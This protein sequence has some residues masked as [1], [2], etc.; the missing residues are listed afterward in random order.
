MAEV[1][2]AGMR[3]GWEQAIDDPAWIDYNGHL[4]VAFYALIFDQAVDAALDAA[5]LG[6]AYRAATGCSVFVLETH[7]RFAAEVAAGATVQVGSRLLAADRRRAVFHHRMM[8]AGTAAAVALQEAL[9]IHVDLGSR[10]SLPW[11]PAVAA[12]L[13]LFA[14]ADGPAPADAGTAVGL[15]RRP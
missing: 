15:G 5:G 1:S 12:R 10:R 6:P 8:L 14:E 2:V 11:P 3:W 9:C 13:A 7:T 4:N